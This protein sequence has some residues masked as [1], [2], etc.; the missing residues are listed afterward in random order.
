VEDSRSSRVYAQKWPKITAKGH[1]Y[2][3]GQTA[4]MNAGQFRSKPTTARKM[5]QNAGI[6]G[7]K[8]HFAIHSQDSGG[9]K[10]TVS[11]IWQQMNIQRKKQ[12]QMVSGKC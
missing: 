1:F 7:G 3:F 11:R 4:W 10:A 2:G 9:R 5:P 6:A 8:R 12:Q